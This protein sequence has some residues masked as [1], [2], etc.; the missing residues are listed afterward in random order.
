MDELDD[1]RGAWQ[2][3]SPPPAY[4]GLAEED[5]LTQAV[6]AWMRDAWQSVPA[7]AARG[8]LR[9]WPKAA[10][11]LCAAA[12]TLAV[13][14]LGIWALAGAAQRVQPRLESVQ[15]PAAPPRVAAPVQMLAQTPERLEMR[16]GA[17]RLTVFRQPP[18]TPKPQPSPHSR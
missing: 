16:S 11:A 5:A 13:A 3:L 10:A 15:A 18:P 14:A 1:L 6:V 17:V 2:R 4:R 7:P 12:A 9:R 8:R